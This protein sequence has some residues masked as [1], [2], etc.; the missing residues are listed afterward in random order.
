MLFDQMLLSG[1]K[2]TEIIFPSVLKACSITK[3]L[4]KGKQIHGIL[5][6]TGFEF[7]VFVAKS[8]VFMYENCGMFIDSRKLFDE[9]PEKNVSSWNALCSS[10]TC[11]GRCEEALDLF[12]EMVTSG[13]KLNE[14]SLW[15]IVN[16]CTGCGNYIQGRRAHGF[17]IKLGYDSD[18]SLANALVRL[19]KSIHDF[20]DANVVSLKKCST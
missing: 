18:S 6:A 17:L 1:R 8:L 4:S 11:N 2:F 16:A 19:Y 9:M 13:I 20:E 15:S 5:I 7:D 3:N 14:R 10:Y 12:Q